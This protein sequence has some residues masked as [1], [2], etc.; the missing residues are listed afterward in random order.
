MRLIQLE[1]RWAMGGELGVAYTG[2][3]KVSL[4]RS[5]PSAPLIDAAVRSEQ[6]RVQDYANQHYKWLPVVKLTVSYSC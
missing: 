5:G 4:T 2:D 6:S 3:Q 1:C